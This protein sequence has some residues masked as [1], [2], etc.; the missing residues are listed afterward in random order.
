MAAPAVASA[1]DHGLPLAPPPPAEQL[2]APLEVHASVNSWFVVTLL[3]VI[4]NLSVIASTVSCA[5]AE[6]VGTPV[7]M[8][9]QLNVNVNSPV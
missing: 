6:V 9:S 5:C 7:A 8:L 3:G 1:P 2:L 4:V